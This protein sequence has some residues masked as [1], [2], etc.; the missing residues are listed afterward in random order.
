MGARFGL[1]VGRLLNGTSWF[2]DSG[3]T[4]WKLDCFSIIHLVLGVY[5]CLFGVGR[6]VIR[7]LIYNDSIPTMFS[8][9]RDRFEPFD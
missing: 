1:D 6:K 9:S 3:V 4:G 2:L 8:L 7:G 5:K